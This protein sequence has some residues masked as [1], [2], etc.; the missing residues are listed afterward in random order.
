[1]LLEVKLLAEAKNPGPEGQVFNAIMKFKSDL[2]RMQA[3]CCPTTFRRGQ[4]DGYY[5]VR[6][7]GEFFSGGCILHNRREANTIRKIFLRHSI[8]PPDFEFK[9][10]L[11]WLKS[12]QHP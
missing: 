5:Q 1:M 7:P 2:N 6:K 9:N 3:R 11:Q 10:F 12:K 8:N 4:E